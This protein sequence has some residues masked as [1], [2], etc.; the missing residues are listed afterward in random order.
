MSFWAFA[1]SH[2]AAAAFIVLFLMMGLTEAIKQLM[3]PFRKPRE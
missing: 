1:D 2:P 3:K